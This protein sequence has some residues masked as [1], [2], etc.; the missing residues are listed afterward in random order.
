MWCTTCA[1]QCAMQFDM[2]ART[3]SNGLRRTRAA[4]HLEQVLLLLHPLKRCCTN[5]VGVV[6]RSG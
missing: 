6:E 5:N 1:C 2:A 4:G 3:T